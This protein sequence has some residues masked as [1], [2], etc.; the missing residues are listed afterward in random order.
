MLV[1]DCRYGAIKYSLLP[2]VTSVGE[3]LRHSYKWNSSSVSSPTCWG[4]RPEIIN[5]F[6]G[7]GNSRAPPSWPYNSSTIE[8][9]S[10]IPPLHLNKITM[11]VL[12]VLSRKSGVI[13]GQD[14]L[15]L[16]N[17]CQEHNF[18]IPAIVSTRSASRLP[19]GPL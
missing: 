13:V 15:A 3:L 1:A 7:S 19:S 18:A 12:D 16:F 8:H 11:G 2:Y 4:L 9:P 5:Y 10:A 14:V 6:I 17:Y